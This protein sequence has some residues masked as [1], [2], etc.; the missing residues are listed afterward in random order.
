MESPTV[1]YS[2]GFRRQEWR[3]AEA[4]WG[5]PV[6]QRGEWRGENDEEETGVL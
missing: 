2:E 5:S 4:N 3:M 6:A 1:T